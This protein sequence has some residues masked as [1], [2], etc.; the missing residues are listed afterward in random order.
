M[1]TTFRQTHSPFVARPRR[2][3]VAFLGALAAVLM[4]LTPPV[5]NA[6]KAGIVSTT[7]TG[8]FENTATKLKKAIT[9]NKLVIVK[10]VPFTQMLSMVGVK[11]EKM[12][13]FEVFHPRFGKVIYGKDKSAFL[14]APLRLLL[15]DKGGKI[16]ISYRKPSVVFS[17]YSGLAGLGKDL[18]E[19]F[20]N[21]V[22]NVAK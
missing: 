12:K 18:D 21:I 15:H 3:T 10:E 16:E 20:A 7:V 17:G 6:E 14:E 11:S 5:A 19:M 9:A 4:V 2:W 13:G 22:A 8:S 1:R